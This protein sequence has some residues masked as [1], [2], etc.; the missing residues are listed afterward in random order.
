MG[1]GEGNRKLVIV[2]YWRVLRRKKLE[3]IN[4]MWGD[5]MQ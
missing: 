5:G 3:T 4:G 2:V 1:C